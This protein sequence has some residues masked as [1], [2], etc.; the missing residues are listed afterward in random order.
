MFRFTF[1]L[2]ILQCVFCVFSRHS[3]SEDYQ[4]PQGTDVKFRYFVAGLPFEGK[5]KVVESS[6]DI[7]FR[8]PSKSVFSVKFDLMQSNAGFPI[9]TKAMKQVLDAY[10]FPIVNFESNSVELKE[11]DF[12]VRGFLKIRDISKPV[13]LLVTAIEEYSSASEKIQFSIRAKF[14]RRR[15]GADAYYP[16][17]NEAIIIE[18]LLTLNKDEK[19]TLKTE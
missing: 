13:N 12:K 4:L 2:L 17:V 1:Y 6:F 5:F 16:L 19:K 8:N 15:F 3:V 14:D 9:A 11:K 7:N 18:D 10:T